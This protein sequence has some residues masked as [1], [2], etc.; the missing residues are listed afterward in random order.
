VKFLHRTLLK[1]ATFTEGIL[2]L[3]GEL[4]LPLDPIADTSTGHSTVAQTAIRTLR[5]TLLDL[6][7]VDAWRALQPDGRDYTHYSTFHRRYSHID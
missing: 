6:R 7:L 4:N 5:R 2:I 3:G 1:L